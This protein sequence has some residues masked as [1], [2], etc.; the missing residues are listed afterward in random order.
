METGQPLPHAVVQQALES[1]MPPEATA[2]ERQLESK[3][4]EWHSIQHAAESRLEDLETRVVWA[5][6]ANEARA[7]E[8]LAAILVTKE[9]L[10][11][12]ELDRAKLEAKGGALRFVQSKLSDGVVNREIGVAM[13]GLRLHPRI[14]LSACFDALLLDPDAVVPA[15]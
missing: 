2:E 15:L 14:D 7:S 13:R 10:R 12:Y 3:I 1:M 6:R 4:A 11:Q 5:Q 9:A 8:V